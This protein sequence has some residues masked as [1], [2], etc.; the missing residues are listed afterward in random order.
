MK[1]I[2]ECGINRCEV[3]GKVVIFVEE[4]GD[5]FEIG[6]VS[7]NVEVIK[8]EEKLVSCG[9]FCFDLFDNSPGLCDEIVESLLS[10]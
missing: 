7:D 10:R 6:M 9:M 1:F 2:G 4:F 5:E 8:N 3:F